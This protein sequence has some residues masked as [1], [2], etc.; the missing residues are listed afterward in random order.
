MRGEHRRVRKWDGAQL[1]EALVSAPTQRHRRTLAPVSSPWDRYHWRPRSREDGCREWS[2]RAPYRR[3][4]RPV[5]A[6]PDRASTAAHGEYAEK[7]SGSQEAH[8]AAWRPRRRS[9]LGRPRIAR[10]SPEPGDLAIWYAGL[11]EE[12]L[13]ELESRPSWPRPH[14]LP[15][16]CLLLLL[17]QRTA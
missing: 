13:D 15:S 4:R 7:F 1:W 17:S 10:G 8:G 2:Q 6:G 3:W 14:R 16:A 11:D 9:A 12:Q 5:N